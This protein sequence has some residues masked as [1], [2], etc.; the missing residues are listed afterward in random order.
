MGYEEI[1]NAI[2]MQLISRPGFDMCGPQ[3]DKAI[4]ELNKILEQQEL[5]AQQN[6]IDIEGLISDG[7]AENAE[8][9]FY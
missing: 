1:I 9:G 2:Y 6:H 5:S 8:N 4:L 3:S 7:F